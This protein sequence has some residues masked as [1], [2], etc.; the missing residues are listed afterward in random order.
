[1][2]IV[3]SNNLGV[4]SSFGSAIPL[5]IVTRLDTVLIYCLIISAELLTEIICV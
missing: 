5:F 3:E 2:D 1:M 4:I